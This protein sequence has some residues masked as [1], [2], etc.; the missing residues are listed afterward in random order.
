MLEEYTYTDFDRDSKQFNV[1]MTGQ[2]R[3]LHKKDCKIPCGMY[4]FIPFDTIEEVKEF[5]EAHNVQFKPCAICF[6]QG[7]K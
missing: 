3:T 2:K 7:S 6:K 1:N 5:E 4:H